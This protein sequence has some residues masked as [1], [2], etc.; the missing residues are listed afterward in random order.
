MPVVTLVEDG[1][2]QIS[3]PRGTDYELFFDFYDDANLTVPTNLDS[4][5]AWTPLMMARKRPADPVAFYDS[6]HAS[7]AG[8]LTVVLGPGGVVKNRVA[9]RLTTA[10][11]LLLPV[12][13]G[14]YQFRF[15]LPVVLGNG[16]KQKLKGKFIVEQ[17][18]VR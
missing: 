10:Q 6:T 11:T 14:D 4:P 8:S 3:I 17:D 15:Q 2:F 5:A 12:C 13:E 18:I 9:F 7:F 1:E 16:K